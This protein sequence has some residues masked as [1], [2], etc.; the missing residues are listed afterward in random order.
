MTSIGRLAR[1]LATGALLLATLAFLT[2]TFLTFATARTPV[3]E[4]TEGGP[5]DHHVHSDGTS[6]S[7]GPVKVAGADD[8]FPG[9][10]DHEHEKPST[11]S[12]PASVLPPQADV[13]AMRS[14]PAAKIRMAD[15]PPPADTGRGNPERPPRTETL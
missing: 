12:L 14:V 5:D 1:R 11:V 4:M 15:Q 13:A 3:I 6:H 7:H 9:A 10:G 2:G 8:A